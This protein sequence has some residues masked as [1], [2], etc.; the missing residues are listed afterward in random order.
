VVDEAPTKSRSTVDRRPTPRP[1]GLDRA[2]TEDEAP[3]N[4][5]SFISNA[6]TLHE[7]SNVYSN[8]TSNA[9]T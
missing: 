7:A 5:L 8:S 9:R 2:G 1:L 3:N 6:S 4:S